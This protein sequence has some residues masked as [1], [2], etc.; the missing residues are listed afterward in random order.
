[1]RFCVIYDSLKA[2]M[3]LKTIVT[4]RNSTDGA[5]DGDKYDR[6]VD[7]VHAVQMASFPWLVP[8]FVVAC[9]LNPIAPQYPSTSRGSSTQK[10]VPTDELAA[11]CGECGSASG[12]QLPDTARRAS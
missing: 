5:G 6:K 1:M 9:L 2:R 7:K 11:H 8:L 4:I 10:A 12:F 3:K